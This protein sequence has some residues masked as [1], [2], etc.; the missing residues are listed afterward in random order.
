MIKP[1]SIITKIVSWATSAS[2]MI[3]NN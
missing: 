1:S 3:R 2:F